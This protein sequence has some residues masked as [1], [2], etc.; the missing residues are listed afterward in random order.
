[1]IVNCLFRYGMSKYDEPLLVKVLLGDMSLFQA[2]PDNIHQ[3]WLN[4]ALI[5]KLAKSPKFIE[6][7]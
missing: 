2:L 3:G 6:E 1:M 4:L 5:L 7:V